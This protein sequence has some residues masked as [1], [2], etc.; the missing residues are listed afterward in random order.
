MTQFFWPNSTRIDGR[1]ALFSLGYLQAEALKAALCYQIE[2]LRFGKNRCEQNLRLLENVSSPGHVTD[3]FDLCCNFWQN[4]F[5][6]Y[7]EEAA[8]MAEIGSSVAATT[9]KRVRQ[10]E[11][12]LIEDLAAQTAM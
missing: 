6:D 1:S 7:S 10:G 9:A 11:K 5:L 3:A 4:A 2:I 8:R 12:L